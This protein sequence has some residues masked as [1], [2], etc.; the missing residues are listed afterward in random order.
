LAQGLF[1]SV[2]DET[3]IDRSRNST[4]TAWLEVHMIQG[5]GQAIV[6]MAIFI[7]FPRMTLHRP[8]LRRWSMGM[9]RRLPQLIGQ[10]LK[11]RYPLD[12]CCLRKHG[13]LLVIA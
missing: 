2:Q 9:R 7:D 3:G 10:S 13:V 8:V 12:Q 4:A 5:T 6:L 1:Q 11:F